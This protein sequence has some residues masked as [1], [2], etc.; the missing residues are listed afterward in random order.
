M[1]RTDGPMR[2]QEI[3]D[4]IR[5]TNYVAPSR[6]GAFYTAIYSVLNRSKGRFERVDKGFGA[7]ESKKPHQQHATPHSPRC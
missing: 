6:P 5:K 2:I 1:E 7:G 3:I 4:E